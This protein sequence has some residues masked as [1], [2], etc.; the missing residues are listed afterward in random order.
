MILRTVKE[1][2]KIWINLFKKGMLSMQ[3]VRVYSVWLYLYSFKMNF[4]NFIILNIY[5]FLQYII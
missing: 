4:S 1:I 5:D 3:K 2:Q